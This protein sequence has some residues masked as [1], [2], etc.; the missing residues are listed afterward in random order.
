MGQAME[1]A[2]QLVQ[3]DNCLG[4]SETHLDMIERVLRQRILGFARTG[5]IFDEVLPREVSTG[6]VRNEKDLYRLYRYP[7]DRDYH[8]DYS[9]GRLRFGEASPEALVYFPEVLRFY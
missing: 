9:E 6:K 1:H 4:A 8:G 3:A 5:K 2:W 7:A